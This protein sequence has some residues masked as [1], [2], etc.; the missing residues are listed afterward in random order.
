MSAAAVISKATPT[1]RPSVAL[2]RGLRSIFRD[3][4]AT[5]AQKL[6]AGRMLMVL[7]GHLTPGPK[8]MGRAN[9][10]LQT[11]ADELDA[12]RNREG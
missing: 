10:S 6:E 9:R 3:S 2:I 5:P 8:K 4:R 1:K 12:D 7:S 11:L